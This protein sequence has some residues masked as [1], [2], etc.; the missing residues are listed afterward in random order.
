MA[1][2][3]TK[4]TRIQASIGD[5]RLRSC[6]LLAGALSLGTSVA[7]AQPEAPDLA[8]EPAPAEPAAAEAAPAPAPEPGAAP[9]AAEAPAPVAAP[10]PESP[11]QAPPAAP[12][13][14]A[15]TPVAEAKPSDAAEAQTEKPPADEDE[16]PT[17]G[18]ILDATGYLLA[19][20]TAEL[21]L[22]YMGYGITDWLNVGT[23]PA[24]WVI[25]PLF[26]GR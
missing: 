2:A 14:P 21:G 24:F 26:G 7:A 12:A 1:P 10:A 20:R 16:D 15:P 9:A 3:P 4:M 18:H 17:H 13:P 19:G 6:L 5:L 25:G 22:F 23:Q 11:A 8:P